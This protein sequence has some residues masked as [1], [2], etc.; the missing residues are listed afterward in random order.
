MP[1]PLEDNFNDIVG[2][3]ARGQKLAPSDLAAKTG[4]SRE[5]VEAVLD[6]EFDAPALRQLAPALG[7]D[8][9]ALV[10]IADKSYLPKAL[11]LDGLAQFT[12]PW[13]D[14]MVNNY[15]VWDPASRAAAAFDSGADASPLLEEAKKRGLH[16]QLILI[17]HT[18]GDH[19]FDLD[20]LREQT[21]A[22]AYVGE[23][24][25]LE[26]AE[27]FAAGRTFEL[28]ALKIES[29]LTWGHSKGGITFV[30][31]G[32]AQPVAV[33]GDA[34]FAG[35]M[36]GGM[37]SYP[38]ALETNRRELFSLPDET[39]LCSGHGPLTT[40]AEEKRHNPFFAKNG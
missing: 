24:E 23:R 13:E 31:R 15:L 26:G 8:A 17:T 21:K 5:K 18:H 19:V 27:G 22:P 38:D 39:I 16:I 30:V 40:V 12:T 11:E 9:Q 3:A 6:G 20:R 25:P 1:L 7:L 2:K 10:G 32:L 37:I 29:R 34:V 14:M 35:S 4:L 36:G 33:V 28:G